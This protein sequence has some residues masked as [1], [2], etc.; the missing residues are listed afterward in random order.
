MPDYTIRVY[1]VNYYIKLH[2]P[3][4]YAYLK[5]NNLPIDIVLQKWIMTLFA[6]YLD[7]EKLLIVFHF[8]FLE[9]WE[10]IIKYCFILLKLSKD[11]L[12]TFDLELLSNFSKNKDWINLKFSSKEFYNFYFQYDIEYKN[13]NPITNKSLSDLRDQFYID[14]VENKLKITSNIEINNIIRN[15]NNVK[16]QQFNKYKT[17]DLK[18]N[19]NN[20]NNNK[21]S[22]WKDDQ[23]LA[24]R[25]YYLEISK[26]K[27]I[28]KNHL[29]L[30]KSNIENLSKLCKIYSSNYKYAIW[31]LNKNKDNLINLIDEK[32]GLET[33]IKYHNDKEI[34]KES[35]NKI[36]KLKNS[37]EDTSLK[38]NKKIYNKDYNDIKTV[39][40]NSIINKFYKGLRIKNAVNYIT[41]FVYSSNNY[42][43]TLIDT[44]VV[45]KKSK[46]NNNTLNNKS[47]SNKALIDFKKDSL[48]RFKDRLEYIYKKI[49]ENN[50]DLNEEV[51]KTLLLR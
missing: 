13:N 3:D 6:N 50:K 35:M 44:N 31:K 32:V 14:L 4:L 22:L 41:N 20:N 46:C 12:L 48:Y 29:N 10:A 16:K 7:L 38:L 42:S 8:F 9:G 18:N 45:L 21:S 47:F 23:V 28:F 39:K 11:Q 26:I 49:E 33:I 37:S 25:E 34:E 36:N 19:N 40:N 17:N 1:Q 51:R 27:N 5:L 43:N 30:L 2:L 15:I 24:I